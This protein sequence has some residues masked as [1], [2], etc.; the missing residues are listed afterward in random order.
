M[1]DELDIYYTK[2]SQ[3]KLLTKSYANQPLR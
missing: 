1:D 3:G 2:F